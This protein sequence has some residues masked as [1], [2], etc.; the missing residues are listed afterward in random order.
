MARYTEGSRPGRAPRRAMREYYYQLPR[1]T[2]P[3]V[4]LRGRRRPRCGACAGA[5]KE[6]RPPLIA[7]GTLA[8]S[9]SPRHRRRG[10]PRGGR[11][12]RTSTINALPSAGPSSAR[13]AGLGQLRSAAPR[14]GRRAQR[15]P[16]QSTGMPRS[17]PVG[18]LTSRPGL[19]E[20]Q[21]GPD[22]QGA[23]GGRHRD[24]AHLNGEILNEQPRIDGPRHQLHRPRQPTRLTARR[25]RLR[26]HRDRAVSS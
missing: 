13:A 21:H 22:Y 10:R 11:R 16:A 25:G 17:T 5:E 24:G 18:R 15:T 3:P 7:V 14:A 8:R 9:P 1:R 26:R 12:R 20:H 19:V 6:E 4:Q 2:G 23:Q